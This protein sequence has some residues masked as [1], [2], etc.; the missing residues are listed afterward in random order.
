VKPFRKR[1][2][3]SEGVRIRAA[4]T[5]I[6]SVVVGSMS[7]VVIG[8]AA[9]AGSDKPVSFQHDIQ[10]IFDEHCVVC[11]QTGAEN[12]GLNL[13]DGKSL[14]FLKNVHSTESGLLR[15]AP[16]DGAHSYLL[17][18]IK[19]T[20]VQAG[21]SGAQMPLGGPALS[22][23]EIQVIEKWIQSEAP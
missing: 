8:R 13:E 14:S 22:P 11:H 3:G 17:H 2:R 4:I 5:A 18:K 19:G 20:Q 16:G 1:R 23:E 12:G 21:G 9:L 15:I 6:A 10:P 7:L